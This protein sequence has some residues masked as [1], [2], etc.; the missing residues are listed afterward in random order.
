[1]R[2]HEWIY[3]EL[4]FIEAN[5]TKCSIGEL[6]E[7]LNNNFHKGAGIRSTQDVEHILRKKNILNKNSN[8]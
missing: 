5:K 3:P 7:L 2:K 6:T 4:R 1:M 8:L